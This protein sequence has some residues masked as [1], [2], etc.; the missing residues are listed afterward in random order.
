MGSDKLFTYESQFI[1]ATTCKCR[2]NPVG[3]FETMVSE[4]K[5]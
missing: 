5:F 4:H 3:L 2:I 1:G